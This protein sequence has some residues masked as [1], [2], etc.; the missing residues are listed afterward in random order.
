MSKRPCPKND[1]I[2]AARYD[3]LVEEF[4]LVAHMEIRRLPREFYAWLLSASACSW[5]SASEATA[6]GTGGGSRKWSA[7]VT[8]PRL[9]VIEWQLATA[10]P[11]R[12]VL[13]GKVHKAKRLAEAAR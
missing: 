6:S 9:K 10:D 7:S 8:A 5:S 2:Q 4:L 11:N 3:N 1:P 13:L 12:I